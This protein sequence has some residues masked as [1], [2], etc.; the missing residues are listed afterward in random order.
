[1]SRRSPTTRRGYTLIEIMT[2]LAI[3]LVGATGIFA[4][5]TG[6]T[7]AN[8]EARR[9][10][11]ATQIAQMVVERIRRD[12]VSWRTGG[13]T[14]NLTALATTRYLASAPARGAGP[15]A[16]MNLPSVRTAAPR[17]GFAFD[18]HGRDTNPATT[19]NDAYCAQMRLAWVYYGQALRADV[20]VYYPRR[21]DSGEAMDPR[22]YLG[23]PATIT[24]LSRTYRN[25]LH[26]AHV[27]TVVRW[28]PVRP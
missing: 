21:G 10:S 12:A 8:M 3:L 24:A 18:F 4:I 27:S 17:E 25:D 23:C 7:V 1:M 2:A 6:A 19:A 28:T 5:Q 15:S 22:T 9:M 13:A 26:F 20:R 16:W 11:T 14:M